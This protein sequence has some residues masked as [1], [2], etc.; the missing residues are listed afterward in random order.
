[1][2]SD[3]QYRQGVVETWNPD[4][5]DNSIRVAGGVLLNL[6]ALTSESAALQTGDVV[7]LL[8][9]GNRWFLLGKVT[10]P[11]DP[12]TVPTWNTDITALTGQ[13]DTIQTVT[14][15]AVQN[16]VTVVQGDV[17]ELNTVTVP[18]VQAVADAAQTTADAAQADVTPL[19]PLTDLAAVT[20]GTTI[21]GATQESASSGPRVVINDPAHPGEITLYTDDPAEQTP[22]R[23]FPNVVP[24]N[25]AMH[26]RSPDLTASGSFARLILT[27]WSDGQTFATLT[28]IHV[29]VNGVQSIDLTSLGLIRI[30][31]D[32][33]NSVTFDGN[34]ITDADLSD[35]SNVF[36][37]SLATLAGSQELT[38]K[39]LSDPTNAFPFKGGRTGITTDASGRATITH[40]MGATPAWVVLTSENTGTFWCS[41]VSRSSTTFTV[42][43]NN[44][45][46]GVLVSSAFN[47]HW[48]AGL[49]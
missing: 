19:L 37:S 40:G 21:T 44:K 31:V 36:P 20:D 46:A 12:G 2:A 34:V 15:P 33:S 22:A 43:I 23:I 13:V 11:G 10:T 25:G 35:P 48:F 49:F 38:N 9:A 18:A 8:S 1:M 7:A 6:P 29:Q 14:I 16:D 41:L 28:A 39:D 27:G 24:G 42:Q 26:L 30:G 17:V 47:V 3:T 32:A 4:T 5:G 45:D